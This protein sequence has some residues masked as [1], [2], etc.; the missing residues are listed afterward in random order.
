M[1]DFL[2]QFAIIPKDFIKDF[3]IIAKENYLDD[4]I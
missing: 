1:E 3:F 2:N 4:E